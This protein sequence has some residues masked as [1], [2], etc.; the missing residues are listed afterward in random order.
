MISIS[1]NVGSLD[2]SIRLLISLVFLGLGLFGSYSPVWQA[3]LLL[4]GTAEL[5]T[6]ISG[7]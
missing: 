3:I 1:Q 7:Y 5:L 6:S 4:L 2:R